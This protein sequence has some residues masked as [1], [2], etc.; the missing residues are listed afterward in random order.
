MKQKYIIPGILSLIALYWLYSSVCV[1]G[2]W[3][4]EG[5]LG[6]FMPMLASI[7]T[8]GF[9]IASMFKSPSQEK[10]WFVT[11]FIPVAMVIVLVGMVQVI[12][13]LPSLAVMLFVWFKGLEKYSWGFSLLMTA[14][15]IGVVWA[16]FE[17]WLRVPFPTGMF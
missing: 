7:I 2:I 8:L 13:M 3:D 12:G 15:V 6:G 14:C 16:V 1:Y 10:P 17:L 4:E 5:P 11:I 9:S